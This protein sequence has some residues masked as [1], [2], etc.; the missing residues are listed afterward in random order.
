MVLSNIYLRFIFIF[1]FFSITE[2]EN[3]THAEEKLSIIC[4]FKYF[5]WF[6]SKS[7]SWFC[8]AGCISGFMKMQLFLSI[9][10]IVHFISNEIVH[11]KIGK[12]L[13]VWNA[14]LFTFCRFEVFNV[15][16]KTI[17]LLYDFTFYQ[18]EI[19]KSFYFVCFYSKFNIISL[20]KVVMV[21]CVVFKSIN[22][23]LNLL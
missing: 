6:L 2:R 4:L 14:G 7:I 16:K 11:G 10:F 5:V 1:Y 12:T 20:F 22:W 8:V 13:L 3:I 9:K 17:F 19:N 23:F 15:T 18:T 21:V